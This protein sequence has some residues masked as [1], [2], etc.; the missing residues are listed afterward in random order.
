MHGCFL[1]VQ[2]LV[3][4]LDI[5]IDR[6]LDKLSVLLSVCRRNDMPYQLLDAGFDVFLGIARHGRIFAGLAWLRCR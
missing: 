5:L 3:G 1:L 6:L 2:D 4:Q